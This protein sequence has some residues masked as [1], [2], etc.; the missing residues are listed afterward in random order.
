MATIVR[1]ARDP[2]TF[3][4][5]E[6]WLATLPAH[7]PRKDAIRAL[8]RSMPAAEREAMQYAWEAM[9]ARPAQRL[10]RGEWDTWFIRAGRGFG[11][12]RTGAEAVRKLVGQGRARAVTIISRTASDA[13][14][15]MIEGPSGVLAVHPKDVRPEYRPSVRMLN[16]PNGAIAHVRSAEEP[17]STLGLNSD[18]IWGD[19]PASWPTGSAVWDNAQLGN[20]LGTPHA[21]LT[22][23]PRPLAWLKALEAEPGTV[24]STGSTY[25]NIGNLARQFIDLVVR[26][27]EGTRLGLQELHAGYLEDVEGALWRLAVIDA[28]R[29]VNV[30]S[31]GRLIDWQA[32]DPW[33][34]LTIGLSLER[35]LAAGFGGFVLDPAERRPWETWV[36]VDPPAETAECGIVVGAAPRRARATFDHAVILD[37][38]STE[39]ANS[40]V[41]E[42][43]GPR[44]V[45]AVRKWG[46]TGVVVERNQGGDMVRS[47]IHAVDANIKVEKVTA[48]E[49]K[50]DR[51]EPVSMLYAQGWVHHFGNL[52]ALENQMTT[53]VPEEGDS[54]DRLDAMV[55]L[56]TKLLA[57]K[58]ARR[59]QVGGLSRAS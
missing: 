50:A 55:H 14:D 8:A 46:A 37:D 27:Y 29:I 15:V 19:E 5:V 59:A 54:P 44:V 48:S 32:V 7:V 9:W 17:D 3:S 21:I 47:T 57:I 33:G 10:P 16:W 52:P 38:M 35:R 53:W 26:R 22:G 4:R 36:G 20:R 24:V 31:E 49:S 45:E 6:R 51:A 12:T 56:V 1:P 34:L 28:N 2:A 18:L 13:R 43:W 30:T 39:G 25:E 41:P 11:K 58:P 23:T 42:V 40:G